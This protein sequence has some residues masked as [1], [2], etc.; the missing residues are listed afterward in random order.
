MKEIQKEADIDLGNT[1]LKEKAQSTSP[2]KNK[3]SFDD[4]P[5]H[6][7]TINSKIS[8]PSSSKGR[9]TII[10]KQRM[11]APRFLIREISVQ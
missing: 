5:P 9:L 11:V 3:Q 10:R 2:H 7:S 4:Q 1:F 6:G 8:T